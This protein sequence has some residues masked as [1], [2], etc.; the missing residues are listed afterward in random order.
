MTYLYTYRLTSDTGLAPCVE[1]GLL[2][3]ACCKG[4]Q[5]RN[6]KAIHTGL[7]Y[8]I[9]SMR[10]GADHKADDVYLLGTYKNNFLYLAKVTDVITMNEYFGT[11]SKGRTDNIYSLKNGRLVRNQHLRNEGVHVDEARNI[12]DI[13]GEY[14]ML[15]DNFIYLGKDAVYI[16]IVDKYGARFRET[17]L[18]KGE[19]A[20]QIVSECMKF[21]DSK[22]HTPT[23][24]FKKKC[25]GCR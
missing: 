20:E 6:G 3:L 10:D 7:R 16:E 12:R 5:I 13:A 14:V 21:K 22:L 23:H 4:G 17:K 11:M 25:G 9:G 2:S 18:Y 15:S 1:N 24:P 19:L 8:R